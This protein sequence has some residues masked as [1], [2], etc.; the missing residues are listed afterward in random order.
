MPQF[1][2]GSGSL[3]IFTADLLIIFLI[4]VFFLL[5]YLHY[6]VTVDNQIEIFGWSYSIRSYTSFQVWVYYLLLS[7]SFTGL[8]IIWMLTSD[9]FWGVV[10]LFIV[11]NNFRYFMQHLLI[12]FNFGFL[13]YPYFWYL[14][15]LVSG[16][17][18]WFIYSSTRYRNNSLQMTIKMGQANFLEAIKRSRW[19]NTF[20]QSKIA[21]EKDDST[22]IDFKESLKQLDLWKKRLDLSE[23]DQEQ[24]FRRV[25]FIDVVFALVAL[26]S[27]LLPELYRFVPEGQRSFQILG[28]T[29]DVGVYQNLQTFSWFLGLKLSYFLPLNIWYF[30]SPHW[31]KH[32]LL[33]PLT[34]A[35]TQL[36]S[37]LDVHENLVDETELFSTWPIVVPLMIGIVW[38]SSR[39][40]KYLEMIKSIDVAEVKIQTSIKGLAI[41]QHPKR[42]LRMEYEELLKNKS[43]IPREK[44]LSELQRIQKRMQE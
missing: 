12:E 18:L 9:K 19:Y 15:V 31:W 39:I 20:F 34:V 30:T 27:L 36:I 42:E 25:T 24:F 44:Y 13:D 11:L 14:F 40:R 10:T 33:I 3:N 41:K 5:P 43:K 2:K 38:I 1:H 6:Y 26:S 4:L 7:F 21:S 35:V 28:Y 37:A 29:Y 32:V 17:L 8:T 16:F 23:N 22:E